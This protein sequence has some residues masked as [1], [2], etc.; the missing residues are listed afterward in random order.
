MLITNQFML[1]YPSCR[2]GCLP[3]PRTHPRRRRRPSPA[4]HREQSPRWACLGY[5]SCPILLLPC[6]HRQLLRVHTLFPWSRYASTPGWSS[7]AHVPPTGFPP[8][9]VLQ[10]SA[11]EVNL[12]ADHQSVH[13]PAAPVSQGLPPPSP[14]SSTPETSSISRIPPT[15]EPA[16]GVS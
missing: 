2:K 9:D 14:Y 15:A 6:P 3:R 13:A 12:H 11:A 7:A 10:L 5:R 8:L 4:S 16:L 1:L